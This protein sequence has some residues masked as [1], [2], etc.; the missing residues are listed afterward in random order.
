[1]LSRSGIK[2]FFDNT[3]CDT[4][5][6]EIP[7]NHVSTINL[8]KHLNFTEVGRNENKTLLRLEK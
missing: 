2:W 5:D 1:M 7:E 8:A 4:L 6:S 3:T